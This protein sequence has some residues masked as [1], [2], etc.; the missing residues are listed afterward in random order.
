MLSDYYSFMQQAV[1][2]ACRNR[3]LERSIFF[4]AVLIF[5]CFRLCRNRQIL[6]TMGRKKIQISRIGDERNRQVN[7]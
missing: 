5:D 6:L 1:W 3:R 2:D 7:A 4:I